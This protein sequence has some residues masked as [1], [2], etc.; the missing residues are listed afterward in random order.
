MSLFDNVIGFSQPLLISDSGIT[1]S[2][3]NAIADWAKVCIYLGHWAK[4][5]YQKDKRRITLIVLPSRKSTSAFIALGALVWSISNYKDGLSW[6]KFSSLNSGDEI[7]WRKIES[8]NLYVGRVV[9]VELIADEPAIKLEITKSRKVRDIGS[10]ILIPKG[11]FKKFQFSLEKPASAQR[12]V[13]INASVSFMAG[14]IDGVSP[15]WSKS[16]GQDL[17]LVT[18]MNEF[19][20]SIEHLKLGSG[21]TDAVSFIELESV[22]GFEQLG[23]SKHSKM[24]ITHPKGD[25]N[26]NA[27]L[28]ILDG[29]AAF[30]IREHIPLINDLLIIFDSFEF[31]ENELDFVKELESAAEPND[32]LK[33]STIGSEKLPVGFEVS[34]Y[35]F[36]RW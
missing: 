30:S 20:S 7:Y 19:K 21:I 23:D 25:L 10:M 13:V 35:Y 27:G 36:G 33:E 26:S 18:K 24:K 5:Q 31:N 3:S 14:L 15:T 9:G 28:V 32:L 6:G 4:S 8:G 34:S 22:L 16:D 12:E 29:P 2:S 17:L 11:Q 1:D